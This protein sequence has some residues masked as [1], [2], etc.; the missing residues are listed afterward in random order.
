VKG[1]YMGKREVTQGEFKEFMGYVPKGTPEER[2]GESKYPVTMVSWNE[3]RTFCETLS[4]RTG[5]EYRLPTEAEWEYACKKMGMLPERVNET[6]R[7]RGWCQANGAFLH[8]AGDRPDE[9]AALPP[10]NDMLGNVEEWC[11]TLYGPYPYPQN[12]RAL[13]DPDASGNRVLRGR[14]SNS[15][16]GDLRPSYRYKDGLPSDEKHLTIGFRVCRDGP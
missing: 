10:I 3:A 14:A 1:F 11:Q 8:K 5:K 7:F 4:K 2:K 9:R 6:P 13:N 12:D 15:P 16:P